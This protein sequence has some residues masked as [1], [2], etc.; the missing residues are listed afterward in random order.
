V[1]RRIASRILASHLLI[2]LVAVLLFS[3]GFLPA[4]LNGLLLVVV[5]VALT[6]PLSRSITRPITNLARSVRRRTGG[7]RR[8]ADG[9]PVPGPTDELA[10]LATSLNSMAAELRARVDELADERDRARQ[11]LDS[12][13]SGVL[14]LGIDGGMRLANTAARDWLALSDQHQGLSARR[15]LGMTALGRLVDRVAATG[16][17]AEE[18]TALV[19]PEP[20]TLSVRVFPLVERGIRTGVVVT[21]VDL[22]RQRRLEALR[23]DFVV[24]ASHELK[25]PVAA[26]RALSEGIGTALEDGDVEMA[27]GFAARADRE[28]ERLDRLVRDLLDLSKVERG[29][30]AIE[31]V[32][33]SALIA[34]VASRYAD[35]AAERDIG[36][37]VRN[38]RVPEI[39]IRGDYDHLELLVS[40][41]LDNALRYTDPGGTVWLRLRPADPAGKQVT[42]EVEDTGRGI[43][44]RELPRV[45]ERFYRVDKARDRSSGGTG[46]GLA[47]VRHIA[48]SHGGKVSAVSELG[49][50]STFTVVLPSEPPGAWSRGATPPGRD[51]GED[52]GYE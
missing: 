12:L 35:R 28:A 41:L 37:K 52:G 43:P 16:E 26:I 24:N 13:D 27:Q 40:N 31:P 2:S 23:R 42:I 5:A 36:V 38:G 1:R 25:T 45:F 19:F 3:F 46:L 6:V 18:H 47:I 22:T 29:T 9:A 32:D 17:P 50:G 39:T 10:D 49:R 51:A 30:L 15:V 4:V 44:S 7:E 48:E 20:R 21:L 34:E 14:L 33:L 8:A 11:I